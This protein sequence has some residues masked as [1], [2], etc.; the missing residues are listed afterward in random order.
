MQGSVQLDSTDPCP[1]SPM[2]ARDTSRG[3]LGDKACSMGLWRNH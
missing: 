3:S 1:L 2:L